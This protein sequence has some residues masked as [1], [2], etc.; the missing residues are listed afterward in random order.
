MTLE[1]VNGLLGDYRQLAGRCGHIEAEISRL[2]QEI[3]REKAEFEMDAAAPPVARLTGLPGG[4]GIAKPTERVALM[5]A[6][7]EAYR[8]SDACRRARQKEAR[9]AALET[10]LE[11]KRLWVRYVN[12]WLNGLADRERWVVEHHVIDG[13]I[14]HDIIQQ[15]NRRYD[16]DVSRD[17]LKR[18]QQRALQKIY[19]MAA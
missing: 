11:E 8:N 15:F 9:I 13:E 10:E 18:I 12:A 3:A 14:W 6:D 7:G 5:L 2:K 4:T 17:R 19:D 1:Q 16:D